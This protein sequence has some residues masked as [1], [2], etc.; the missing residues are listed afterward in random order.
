M[1]QKAVLTSIMRKKNSEQKEKD[2]E[3]ENRYRR[4][5]RRTSG[6]EN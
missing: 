4:A 5:S 6:N 2:E 1:L 3:K